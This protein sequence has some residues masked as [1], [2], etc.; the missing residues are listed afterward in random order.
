MKR[1][2]IILL[3][4]LLG[5]VGRLPGAGNNLEI[6]GLTLPLYAPGS[7]EPS[8]LVK[9]DRVHKDYQRQGFFRIGALPIL[10]ADTVVVRVAD[11]N[12]AMGLL[13]KLDV[14][15]Q[16]TGAAK[17]IEWRR[18]SF[19]FRE[20]TT[21]RLQAR[22]MRVAP[23]EILELFDGQV[24]TSTNEVRFARAR[25]HLSGEQKGRLTARTSPESP[26]VHLWLFSPSNTQ[27]SP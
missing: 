13:A 1:Q 7:V 20:E 16:Q 12:H 21:A 4:C 24:R 18:V 9:I 10:A 5:P 17:A 25:L 6:S 15:L 19:L 8:V 11:T 26:P 22:R 27:Q 2:T 23:G 14:R 3:I